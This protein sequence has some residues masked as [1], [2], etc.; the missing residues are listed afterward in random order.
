MFFIIMPKSQTKRAIEG[1]K[2]RVSAR[3]KRRFNTVVAEYVRVKHKH[4]HE[5]C[6]EFYNNVVGKYSEKQKLTITEEFRTMLE[7]P[8]S[9]ERP[10]PSATA[11][12]ENLFEQFPID[13]LTASR[14]ER[15]EPLTSATAIEENLFEQFPIEPLTASRTERPE[16]LTS[17]TTTTTIEENLVEQIPIDPLTVTVRD[18][19]G[20]I[21]QVVQ[22]IEGVQDVDRII[23]EIINDLDE[24]HHDIFI[25]SQEQ[26]DEGIDL[27]LEDELDVELFQF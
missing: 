6:R 13:P 21:E 19:L 23:N 14:T 3:E 8:K 1:R 10:E 5:E 24:I 11:I 12:E 25:E 4:I 20:D 27:N 2:W 7:R 15:P 9:T 17:T 22:N 26:Q 16:P 18:T